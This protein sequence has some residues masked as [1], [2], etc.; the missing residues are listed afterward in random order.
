MLRGGSFN[1]PASNVRSSYRNNNV[2]NR[3]NNN[4]VR[5]ASTLPCPNSQPLSLRSVPG[6]KVQVVVPCRAVCGRFGQM[7][8]RPGKSGR[9]QGSKALPGLFYFPALTA[10]IHSTS[11]VNGMAFLSASKNPRALTSLGSTGL[12]SLMTHPKGVVPCADSEEV[13]KNSGL[14]ASALVEV[15]NDHRLADPEPLAA[16]LRACERA[17][18]APNPLA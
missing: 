10:L 1:H 8:T 7:I 14:T 3:N 6:C 9:P 11:S 5:P 17:E 12:V 13:V 16:M 4:G 18:A 15:G 2:P